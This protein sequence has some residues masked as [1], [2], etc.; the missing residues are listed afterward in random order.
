MGK[1]FIKNAQHGSDILA[2]EKRNEHLPT[3]AHLYPDFSQ[4][5][6]E[7]NEV[8]EL[9]RSISSTQYPTSLQEQHQ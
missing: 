8:A 7:P 6:C 1:P 3:H 9:A 4:R 5:I 2:T